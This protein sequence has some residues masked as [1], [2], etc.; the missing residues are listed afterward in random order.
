MDKS[1]LAAAILSAVAS[2][3]RSSAVNT[4]RWRG[5]YDL[6]FSDFT[7]FTTDRPIHNPRNNRKTKKGG[8]R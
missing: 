2:T 8:K 5:E 6:S 1:S 7:D 4:D 3:Q